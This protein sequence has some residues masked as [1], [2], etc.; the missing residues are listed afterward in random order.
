[1]HKH[2][3][4]HCGGNNCCAFNLVFYLEF[5]F[6]LGSLGVC[7]VH[8][9]RWA[10]RV[11]CKYDIALA[12]FS[13]T[14]KFTIPHLK[15]L[16]PQLKSDWLVCWTLLL[17][18]ISP[19]VGFNCLISLWESRLILTFRFVCEWNGIGFYEGLIG[20]KAEVLSFQHNYHHHVYFSLELL[21]LSD[22]VTVWFPN[23]YMHL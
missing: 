23:L 1:M 3:L 5:G 11:L 14:A 2:K 17:S 9:Y 21:I 16:D 7:I 10:T 12:Y 19:F 13:V 18:P 15:T 8:S 22:T 6:P 20:F 4:K